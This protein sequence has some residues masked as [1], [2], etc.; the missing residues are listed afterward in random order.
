MNELYF[1]IG[2]DVLFLAGTVSEFRGSPERHIALLQA[3]RPEWSAKLCRQFFYVF[4]TVMAIVT[5]GL[6]VYLAT[7]ISEVMHR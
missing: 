6:T 3:R 5:I 2:L 4:R 7:R 1:W